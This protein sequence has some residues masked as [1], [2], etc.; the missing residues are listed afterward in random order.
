MS[1]YSQKYAL[2][3]E[4]V[5]GTVD[6]VDALKTRVI[7]AANGHLIATLPTSKPT[8]AGT[9]GALWSDSGTVKVSDG[10]A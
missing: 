8:G 6:A 4:K 5:D 9:A 2:N 1:F 3:P 7:V 10:Q